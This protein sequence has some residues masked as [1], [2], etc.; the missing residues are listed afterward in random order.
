M[1]DTPVE[2]VLRLTDEEAAALAAFLRRAGYSEFRECAKDNGE[3]YRML[4]AASELR[5]SLGR[6]GYS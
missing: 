5:A 1:R 3:A 4:H 6:V 2:L